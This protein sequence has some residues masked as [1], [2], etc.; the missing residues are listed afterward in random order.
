MSNGNKL[1]I[2]HTGTIYLDTS[3]KQFQLS[4]ILC[5]LEIKRK[6]YPFLN[7]VIII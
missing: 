1:P 2:T 3:N 6:L 4:N 5:A 7:F